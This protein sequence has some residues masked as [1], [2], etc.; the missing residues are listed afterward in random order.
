MLLNF[1]G[2]YWR[3]PPPS[4]IFN[5]AA[6]AYIYKN[7]IHFFLSLGVVAPTLKDVGSARRSSTAGPS[8]NNRP[9]PLLRF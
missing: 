7:L 9:K 2:L 5:A 4:I 3:A 1:N 6:L 8:D